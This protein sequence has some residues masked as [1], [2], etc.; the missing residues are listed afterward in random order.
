[1]CCPANPLGFD[2]GQL[3]DI[4]TEIPCFFRRVQNLTSS[5]ISIYRPYGTTPFT[6]FVV[7]LFL[8]G[9]D[10]HRLAIVKC[11]DRGYE[12]CSLC[13]SFVVPLFPL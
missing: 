13:C 6:L 12:T 8:Q 7:A 3:E 2:D 5:P 4:N 9:Y 10:L 1:M 11:W